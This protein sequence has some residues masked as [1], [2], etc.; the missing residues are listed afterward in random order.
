MGVGVTE[1]RQW[2]RDQMAQIGRKADGHDDPG[3]SGPFKTYGR[4]WYIGWG[5]SPMVTLGTVK[6]DKTV[7]PGAFCHPARGGVLDKLHQLDVRTVS[8]CLNLR[9]PSGDMAVSKT[10]MKFSWIGTKLPQLACLPTL[11]VAFDTCS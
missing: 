4:M 1:D 11:S 8:C 5:W 7:S 10:N 2:T 3:K 9:K 6:F